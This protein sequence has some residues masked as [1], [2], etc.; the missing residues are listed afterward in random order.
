MR[1]SWRVSTLRARAASLV[2]PNCPGITPAG[3][4][5]SASCPATSSTPG[6]WAWSPAAARS[7]TRSSSSSPSRA[8]PDHLRRHR[9]RPGQR[10]GLHRLPDLFEADPKTE[11]GVLIG[12][13]GGDDEERRRF[14]CAADQQARGRLHGR[15]QRAARQDMGHAGAIISA[16]TAPR[17]PRWRPSRR[18]EFRSR[19]GPTRC[20]DW[21]V[22][23]WRLHGSLGGEAQKTQ[24]H[25]QNDRPDP[26]D[27]QR[28]EP[29]GVG[30]WGLV[31]HMVLMVPLVPTTIINASS[32]SRSRPT[33]AR[34][35]CAQ[36]SAP[37]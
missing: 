21:C 2:G 37:S 32:R 22:R 33:S 5:R 24:F 34:A 28:P 23:R 9:R 3:G 30:I 26:P 13:I 1:D 11:G 7:P 15:L 10:L 31:V 8:R 17:W 4:A 35:G 29:P 25:F 16:G 27:P 14:T 12:E 19:A 18:P 20:P 6:R 36:A